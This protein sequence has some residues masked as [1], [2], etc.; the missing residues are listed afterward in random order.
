MRGRVDC[1]PNDHPGYRDWVAE[2]PQGF[3][4]TI[5]GPEKTPVLTVPTAHMS[6]SSRIPVRLKSAVRRSER[7]WKSGLRDGGM[8]YHCGCVQHV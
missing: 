1:F 5:P 4:L 8:W 3:V 6:A 2:H 7:R